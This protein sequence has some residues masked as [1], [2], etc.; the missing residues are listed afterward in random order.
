MHSSPDLAFRILVSVVSLVS[1][2]FCIPSLSLGCRAKT[3][4]LQCF[5][6]ISK[7]GVTTAF[8]S[9]YGKL[10]KVGAEEMGLWFMYVC[11]MQSPEKG[12]RCP[13][14]SL[15]AVHIPLNLRQ[16]CWSA[17]PSNPLSLSRPHSPHPWSQNYVSWH[18]LHFTWEI[19]SEL[20][21]L[22]M[23]NK[24][25]FVLSTC[26]GK[27]LNIYSFSPSFLWKLNS[28]TQVIFLP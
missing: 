10:S 11:C 19:G 25:S 21:T 28:W 17:K 9:Q 7:W 20:R 1:H 5:P 14:L 6:V 4:M 3:C 2:P 13:A 15:S 18:T 22:C 16:G 8:F 27:N 23:C 24:C 12:V 26:S